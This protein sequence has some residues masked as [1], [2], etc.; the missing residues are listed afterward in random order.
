MK[1][2]GRVNKVQTLRREQPAVKGA[3]PGGDEAPLRPNAAFLSQLRV[4]LRQR[5][6]DA[7]EVIAGKIVQQHPQLRQSHPHR[8][9]ALE[10]VVII[11]VTAMK[12]LGPQEQSRS[13][14]PMLTGAVLFTHFDT[15]SSIVGS[16]SDIISL[17]NQS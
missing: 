1:T 13:A 6:E 17:Y 7:V 3:S 10:T 8:H 9:V 2:G 15:A 14:M 4:K 16:P 11:L 5:Y 12:V